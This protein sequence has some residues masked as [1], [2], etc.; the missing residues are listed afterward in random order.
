MPSISGAV[1]VVVVAR[2]IRLYPG[3]LV[4]GAARGTQ[5][6]MGGTPRGSKP[7]GPWGWQGSRTNAVCC[8][9][10]ARSQGSCL[11]GGWV[12]FF[13]DTPVGK[14]CGLIGVGIECNELRVE[15]F[16]RLG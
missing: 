1:N 6:P 12:L 14:G 4:H 5:R 9:G 7:L 8:V 16:S 10:S 13:V 15:G 2:L 11:D 3:V